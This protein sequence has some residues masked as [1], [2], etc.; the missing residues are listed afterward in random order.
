MKNAISG[1]CKTD[2][3]AAF[4]SQAQTSQMQH[5]KATADSML[6]ISQR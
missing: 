2:Y 4:A 5:S 3:K 6:R 1:L